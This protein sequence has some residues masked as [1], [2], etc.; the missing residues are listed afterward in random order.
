M[1]D[2]N[3]N[4][5]T[6]LIVVN[7]VQAGGLNLFIAWGGASGII[8]WVEMHF[9]SPIFQSQLIEKI[10]PITLIVWILGRVEKNA[11][12]WSNKLKKYIF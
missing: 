11:K 10:R 3:S 2:I 8:V 9:Y 12:K 5:N 7:P 1:Y 4:K 6:N